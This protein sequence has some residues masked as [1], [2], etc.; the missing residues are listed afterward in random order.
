M[1]GFKTSSLHMSFMEKK[2]ALG[3]VFLPIRQFSAVINIPPILCRHFDLYVAKDKPT[4]PVNLSKGNV[5]F[6][7]RRTLDRKVL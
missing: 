7:K 5:S 4:K 2:G 3:Q 1:P 6:K